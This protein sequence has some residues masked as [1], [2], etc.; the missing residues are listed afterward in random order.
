M[1]YFL[2]RVLVNTLA[3]WLTLAVLPGV[4]INPSIAR[5]VAADPE[6]PQSLGFFIPFFASI[7]LAMFFGFWNWLLWPVILFFTGQIVIWTFGLYLIVV[8]VA[9]FYFTFAFGEEPLVVAEHPYWF[10]AAMGGMIFTLWLF[11]LEGITGINSPLKDSPNR[12]RRYWRTLARFSV[13]RRNYFTENR[14]VAQSIDT[15][16]RYGRDIAFDAVPVVGSVR[17]TF[18]RVIYWR[19]KPL[20]DESAAETV[21]YML[22]DLGPTYVKLGQIISSRAESL[23]VEWRTQLA[24]LQSEVEPF[25]AAEAEQIITAQLGKPPD[26]L[27][28]TFDPT[29]LAAASTAQVHRATLRDGCQ[30]VVK[31]QRPDID[32]TVRADLNVIRD[33]T[34]L[35][36][37]R[38]Q[39]ARRADIA[40][41]TSE[42]ADNILMELDYT[43]EAFNGRLLAENMRMFPSVHVPVIYP[44]L[45][46]SKVL[47][48]EFVSG[49]KITNLA[50][51][52]TAGIDRSELARTFM[53]AM[54]KQVLYDGFFH[55]DPHPGNVLVN[56]ETGQIIFLD[57]GMMGTLTS[58]QRLIFADMI[59]SL[60]GRDS[61]EI[62]KVL[63]RLSVGA[64]DVDEDAFV[65]DVERLLMR[66]T[67][68]TDVNMSIASAMSAV[69][70]ALTRAGLRM[71]AD[72]TLAVKA[73]IQAEETVRTLDP[74]L[75]LVETALDAAKQL[76]VETFDPNRVV[77]ALRVQV[78]RTAKEAVRSIP[79]L[80]DAA[81]SWLE[82]FRRG[83]FTLYF[84]TSD[85]G[86]QIGELDRV[87]TTNLRGLTQALLLVGLLIGGG[88]ASTADRNLLPN[89]PDLA[90]IVFMGAALLSSGMI[91]HSV[92]RWLDRGEW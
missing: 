78:V 29:P 60:A 28:A 38:F 33:L 47:V 22:Q 70:D 32:I 8:N 65:E 21:R 13:G 44:T 89:L 63:L 20:I 75:P 85:L 31:V 58:Q 76:F 35:T 43:T 64:T 86:K 79:S 41:I 34:R 3:L 83:K 71:N 91:V 62:A 6:I 67:Y 14:R 53:R 92:I 72:L 55:G 16:V 54:V 23:P 90:Y 77:D 19:R 68:F 74:S 66:Y 12:S 26:E 10:W 87:I 51:I 52:D 37:Q 46:T 15:I 49:V 84:D 69:F 36:Q 30:V 81:L 59:W 45:S 50:A 9:L 7:A 82:Q 27:F 61:R 40:G 48:Q 88:V 42:Y 4:G 39:W 18:Q 17:R 11:L 2:V 1:F 25:S 56:P 57:M 80:Q 73:M 24:M 5:E